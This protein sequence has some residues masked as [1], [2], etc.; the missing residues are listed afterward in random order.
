MTTH[1]THDHALPVGW[2]AMLAVLAALLIGCGGDDEAPMVDEPACTPGTAL[3]DCV[4]GGCP[5][6]AGLVCLD[7]QCV[8][9]GC[10]AGAEGC[11]CRADGGCGLGA[12]GRQLVCAEGSCEAAACDAGTRGCPCAAGGACADDLVCIDGACLVPSCERAG[13]EG[14]AC[15]PDRSCDAGLACQLGVCEPLDGCTPGAVDCPCR[16][17]GSCASG[18]SCDT[19]TDTCVEITCTPGTTGCACDE[20]ACSGAD[21]VCID[22]T[23]SVRNCPDG[24]EG[25]ACADGACGVNDRGERL[26]CTERGVCA[27]ATCEP[28]AV[29]CACVDGYACDAGGVC[30]DGFCIA[31][32]CAPG[33]IDCACN[34]GRCNPGATCRDGAICVDGAGY[35]GGPCRADGTCAYGNRCD[36][37]LCAPCYVGTVGC[38]CNLDTIEAGTGDGC[39]RG[40]TC[41]SWGEC[42]AESDLVQDIPDPPFCVT[43]CRRDAPGCPAW[44]F[45]EGCTGDNTCVEGSCVAPGESPPVC[46]MESD[47]PSHQACIGGQCYSTC[48]SDASCGGGTACHE[49]TC[50][51]PCAAAS[52]SCPTG[53]FCELQDATQGFCMPEVPAEPG[54]VT[55]V[56]GQLRIEPTVLT[57]FNGVDGGSVTVTNDSPNA[58]TIVVRKLAHQQFFD[59]GTSDDVVDFDDGDACDPVRGECPMAWLDM[60]ER[61]GE[62]GRVDTFEVTLEPGAQTELII[63]GGGETSAVRWSGTL[64]L[65]NAALGTTEVAIEYAQ[66]PEG[67]WRGTAFFYAQF[68]E[69]DTIDAWAATPETRDDPALQDELSNAFLQRWGAF[70]RGDLSWAEM[71]AVMLATESGQWVSAS[72][73]PECGVAACYLYG[74]R[75]SGV[76]DYSADLDRIP[77]PAGV[78]ELPFAMNL[79]QPTPRGAPQRMVGRIDSA[80]TLHYA[81]NPAVELTFETAPTACDREAF[82]A[83]LSYVTDFGADILVGGRYTPGVGEGC[84]DRADDGFVDLATPWL[85]PD[86]RVGVVSGASGATRPECRDTHL[87]FDIT[88]AELGEIN[89]QLNAGLAGSNPVPDGRT[90]RRRLELLDGVLVNQTE[91]VLIVRERVDS[92][93]DPEGDDLAAY[94]YIVLRRQPTDLGED[95]DGNGVVDAYEGNVQVDGREGPDTSPLALACSDDLL[96]EVLLP[97]E[98]L[99]DPVHAA[100]VI[101]RLVDG[102]DGGASGV[103]IDSE[104]DEAVH[105]LCVETGLFD[106][107]PDNTTEAFEPASR[108]DNA[109]ATARNDR[110]EDGGWNAVR[111]ADDCEDDDLDYDCVVPVTTCAFGTD[112]A[113]CGTRYAADEDPRATCPAGSEVRYF[114]VD[115]ARMSQ[116]DIAALPCQL[117]GTC[118][119]V[120]DR[121]TRNPSASPLVQAEALYR[122]EAGGAYCSANRDDLRAGKRFFAAGEAGAVLPSLRA[123]IDEAFRYRTR[124]RTRR[125]ENPGFAPEICVPGSGE[126]PYCY[127]PTQIEPLVDRIDC[128]LSLWDTRSLAMQ[129][130]DDPRVEDALDLLHDTL[131]FA[132]AQDVACVDGRERCDCSAFGACETFDGFERLYAE[133]LIMQGDDAYTA[134]FASRFDLAGARTSSFEG[135]RFE[136]GGISLSGVAGHEMVNLYQAVQYYTVALDR[137]YRMSPLIWQS[138]EDALAEQANPLSDH[139]VSFV[140]PEMVTTYMERLLRASTQ[141]SRAWSQIATRYHGFGQTALARRVI[142]R[143]YTST[144]LESIAIT[145]LMQRIRETFDQRDRPQIDQVLESAALRYGMALLDMRN[146]YSSINDQ[147]TVFGLDPDFIPFPVMNAG[148]FQADT[149]FEVM[150]RRA[151]ERTSIAAAREDL[152]IAS[153]RSYETDTAQFQSELVSIRTTYESQLGELCGTFVGRDGRVYPAIRR[154]APQ[155]DDLAL[156]GDPCGLAGTG[157]IFEALIGLDLL[158]VEMQQLQE[159]Y[160]QVYQRIEIERDRVDAQCGLIEDTANFTLCVQTGDRDACDAIPAGTSIPQCPPSLASVFDETVDITEAVISGSLREE[161]VVLFENSECSLMSLEQE[162]RESRQVQR[163]ANTAMGT[164]SSLASLTKC[165]VLV[166]TA[167]GSDCAGA[168]LGAS[169]IIGSSLVNETIQTTTQVQIDAT[170]R[171]INTMQYM[172]GH[173][174]TVGACDQLNVDAEAR[175]REMLLELN[176]LDLESLRLQYQLQ[177]AMSQLERMNNEAQRLQ[178][179]QQETEQLLINVEAARNDPNVRIYRNDAILNADYAFESAMALAWQATR[180]YEYYTT[181]SYA[182]RDQLFLIRMVGAGEYNLENYLLDLQDAFFAFE[183]TYGA[184]DLRVEILSLRDDL[185]N[186]PLVDEAGVPLSQNER[187]L[188][189]RERLADPVLLDENGYLT[190]PFSTDTGTLSPL[191]RAHRIQFIEADIIASSYGDEVGRV[192]LRQTGTSVIDRLEGGS[193]FYRFP[194]RSLSVVDAFFGGTRYFE[195]DVYRSYTFLD[196]PFANTAW[197]LVINQR[198]EVA[199]RDIDLQSLTDIRLYVYYNDFTVF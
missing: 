160:H 139:R 5:G 43:P 141:R 27:S 8:Y 122:C 165:F 163:V 146:V 63:A 177:L 124:F 156:L 15:N 196:R 135:D 65:V 180:I 152:A 191:T 166:G 106:G 21:A 72:E 170:E 92:F 84:A 95:T 85:L 125:G 155:S 144:Y 71:Q 175:V 199:N 73:L 96:D 4:Q 179:E 16:R 178:L 115:A 194:N 89:A 79:Y 74:G 66:R 195:A 185:L 53:T 184:P 50:R 32:G 1:R 18:A 112:L 130:S 56:D 36:A 62:V 25:C 57:L 26:T 28:G 13:S 54:G 168:A 198:D 7:D 60:G 187:V 19:T 46:A 87:P 34:A 123:T 41:A 167:A 24:L 117:T 154:Y 37:G 132:F 91:L 133:L 76:G 107:G 99:D 45:V 9:P 182:A 114:T 23:C 75:A 140:E 97:G 38:Q 70:R 118:D 111:V 6:A 149:A 150:F 11:V 3:C 29:G 108:N 81:G 142:E 161:D 190:V 143:A 105:Y 189:L 102:I 119:E 193:S 44:G 80:G 39:G 64:Q 113:D 172:L 136:V 151:Q 88:D 162:V 126:V 67:Q 61:G 157:S 127:D 174:Q 153:S 159:R 98:R 52:D 83:C 12:D 169:M 109:C 69:D 129:R 49:F 30:S 173:F 48:R 42:V 188:L 104:S 121:W 20:G 145:R 147:T 58:Q 192:Y 68:Y 134:A 35:A 2:I 176:V 186:I 120:L 51:T 100:R 77:V 14:C 101:H 103:L 93:F 158:G 110:C 47:C 55:G 10:D 137:F 82:G 22:G 78:S 94:G 138:V 128:L 116:A 148:N 40:A 86:F 59:D 90:R 17:D 197:E 33:A 164:V 171:E 131:A 181:T 31:D 183:E